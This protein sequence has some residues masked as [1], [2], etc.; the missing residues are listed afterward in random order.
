MS[1]GK[2]V[3]VEGRTFERQDFGLFMASAEPSQLWKEIRDSPLAAGWTWPLFLRLLK[4]SWSTCL[5]HFSGG[6]TRSE[7]RMMLMLEMGGF[8]YLEYF[9]GSGKLVK[10]E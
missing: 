5:K 4:V 7:L 10:R 2:A 3:A 8:T 6:W 1:S 9:K